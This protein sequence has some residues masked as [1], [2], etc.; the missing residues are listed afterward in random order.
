[1]AIQLTLSAEDYFSII[2]VLRDECGCNNC[3]SVI[4]RMETS[5]HKMGKFVPCSICSDPAGYKDGSGFYCHLCIPAPRE[6]V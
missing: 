4:S 1:M 3:E 6:A 2:N 5:R